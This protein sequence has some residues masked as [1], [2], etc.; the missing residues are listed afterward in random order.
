M[1]VFETWRDPATKVEF[2]FSHSDES[3]TTGVMY[4]PPHS[5]LP[6]HNRPKAFENLVQITGKCKMEVFDEDGESFE[7]V[8]NPG[9]MLRMEK[10]Q[11]HIHSNP[12]DEKSYTLFK[13]EGDITEIMKVLR[14]NFERIG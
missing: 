7:K 10:G 13:A 11:Y 9:D 1:A 6:K 5:E 3:L 8:L 4:L 14:E 12:Y 2:C